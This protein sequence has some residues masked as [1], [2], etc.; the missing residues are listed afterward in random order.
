MTFIKSLSL[1]NKLIITFFVVVL[2]PLLG[3][4]FFLDS[5]VEKQTKHDFVE[6]TTREV[7]QVD[8]A[9]NL[10]LD[11][12]MQNTKMLATSPLT[13]Q[14]DGKIN[15]YINASAG[16]DGMIPMTPIENGGYEAELYR[17]FEQFGSNHP[18][19]SVVSLG[20]NDG[21]YI[22]WPAV[23]RKK[24]YDSRAR[25]WYK[26]TINTPD[27]V[28]LSDPFM[29][30]K[31]VPTIGIFT[32]VKDNSNTLRGVIGLNVD[33]PAITQMIHNIQIGKSGYV[34]LLDNKGTIIADPKHTELNFKN[35]KDLNVEK[36]N[37][38]NEIAEGSFDIKLDGTDQLATVYTSPT[39]GWKYII[40]VEKSQLLESVNK[41]RQATSMAVFIVLI[42]IAIV[43]YF[44]ARQMTSPLK[45]LEDAANCIATGDIRKM[46]LAVKSNDELGRLAKVFEA[47][48][49]QLRALITNINK[50][51]E[52]VLVLSGELSSGA[53]QS[54]QAVSSVA[55][56]ISEV[57]NASERQ[58]SSVNKMVDTVKQ[59]SDR[60]TKVAANTQ[61][62]ALVSDQTGQAAA[63]GEQAIE[64]AV[65]QMARIESTVTDSAT[66]VSELGER[67]KVIGNI[68][69]TIS[70]IA[71]QTNLLALNAAIEAARAGE[72]GKGFAVVAEEV[73]KLAEQSQEAAKQIADLISD[74]QQDTDKAVNAMTV[75]TQ[76]VKLGSDVVNAAGK[77]FSEIVELI[78]KVSSYAK[79][80]ANETENVADDSQ[81]LVAA[82]EDIDEAT[83]KIAA[84]IETI[85]A[86]TEE[87]SASMQ[88]ISAS[89]NSLSSMADDLKKAISQFKY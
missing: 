8:N 77:Q 67:S 6:A 25:D 7:I 88:Q 59:M 20:T 17:M 14:T 52:K 41:I 36:L 74:I 57:A 46:D 30:S 82:I 72:Q 2:I 28:V 49:E 64:R 43:A 18:Q 75:G 3:F 48:S 55:G 54:A 34:M 38:I 56:S 10:F 47:M 79:E 71:G 23:P 80:S 22:Q 16:A 24:G 1:R 89:S 35:I 33:L 44:I 11:G 73:R 83:K 27:K 31:G 78:S 12:L 85:S 50:S 87:Q 63:N 13:R 29:T 19:V 40:L 9:I 76:E 69:E 65:G 26:D 39:T 15:V 21:G 5:M 32:T 61:D 45:L 42:I 60:I 51:S 58:I 84:D 68:V 81:K 86:A 4:G 53:E 70:N 37:N 62:M 66:V